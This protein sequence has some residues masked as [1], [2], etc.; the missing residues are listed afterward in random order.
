VA[1]RWNEKRLEYELETFRGIANASMPATVVQS[2]G[3]AM[4]KR[5]IRRDGMA[6]AELAESFPSSFVLFSPMPSYLVLSSGEWPP[7]RSTDIPV[8]F[9]GAPGSQHV[10]PRP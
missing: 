4:E 10:Q 5:F 9:P 6:L 2:P 1:R 3:N 7:I 8:G